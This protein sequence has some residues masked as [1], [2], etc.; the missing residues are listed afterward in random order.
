MTDGSVGSTALGARRSPA[1]RPAGSRLAPAAVPLLFLIADT[2]GGHRAAARAVTEA[3]EA[4]Y[5][6]MFAPVLCDPLTGPRSAP[7]LRFVSRLYGPV[8]RLAP[9]AWGAAW[10]LS[11][12]RPVAALLQRTLYALADQPVADLAAACRPAVIVSFHPLTGHAAARARGGTGG[13]AVVTVVTDLV[14]AHASWRTGSSDRVVVP[15]AAALRWFDRGATAGRCVETG[16][17]VTAHFTGSPP[18]EPARAELRRSLGIGDRGFVVL[19]AGGAEGCGG[20]AR[21]AKAIVTRLP[22]VRVV[23]ICG[24]NGRALRTLTALAAGSGGRLM[25]KGFV[26][27]LADWLRCA[28]LLVTKA[29]PGMI[30]EAACCGTPMLLTSH[31]PGQERGNTEF[32]VAAGAARRAVGLR[33]LVREAGL[34]HR[35]PDTL[36]QMRA[37]CA[38]L[39]RRTAAADTAEVIAR[40]AGAAHSGG[41]DGPAGGRRRQ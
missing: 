33:D 41:L 15:T 25:V 22:G 37:S 19:V 12:L 24:R 8:V 27:N 9:W 31:L 20:I 35:D 36:R 14:T 30:A 6:R 7:L 17:P 40:L 4:A 2:G 26:S 5:P 39:A 11:N 3:L 32:A 1:S 10:H 21:Q 34:L 16:L 28:D 23:T 29:G 38:T 13:P 18:S